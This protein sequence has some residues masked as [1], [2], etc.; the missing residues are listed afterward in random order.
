MLQGVSIYLIGMMGTGK[1]TVGEKLAHRLNYRFL[2]LDSLIEKVTGESI[3]DIFAHSG[4]ATFRDIE[5]QVLAATSAYTRTVVAT[6]GGIVLKQ[7]NW[8]YLRHGLIIW[9]DAP[10]GVLLSR[11]MS[12]S[13]RPLLQVD[14]P[15]FALQ[16][17][18]KE[19]LPLYQQADLR[20]L[21]EL[22]QTSDEVV[23]EIIQQIPSILKQ[24]IIPPDY[25]N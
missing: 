1:T 20:I 17:I 9:L 7:M 2:D 16:N 6:G 5:T 4:E 15:S 10:I 14:D 24:P 18:L 12:D 22:Q 23:E 11:L 13:T 21:Q 3:K 25:F 8:S 19:R